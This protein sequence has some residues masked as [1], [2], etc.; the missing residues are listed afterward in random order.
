MARTSGCSATALRPHAHNSN[1]N[2]GCH[3]LIHTFECR[4]LTLQP[5]V[6]SR[7]HNECL[8]QSETRSLQT[9]VSL[10]KK[11]R[12]CEPLL[13]QSTLTKLGGRTCSHPTNSLF[14]I[15]PDKPMVTS[16]VTRTCMPSSYHLLSLSHANPLKH[17]LLPLLPILLCLVYGQLPLSS[18]SSS[19]LS[20][21]FT[22]N[23][24]T[25]IV[26]TR[27]LPLDLP[28]ETHVYLGVTF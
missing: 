14:A 26:H 11:T 5:E 13:S 7:N 25:T 1:V 9:L 27:I 16:T 20:S 3:A 15:T 23:A 12:V 28:T 6:V 10:A 22:C 2:C 4:A 8:V 19:S 17:T 24:T 18:S 21:T